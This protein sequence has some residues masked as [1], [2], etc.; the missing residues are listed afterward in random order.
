MFKKYIKSL[1]AT[2]FLLYVICISIIIIYG[3]YRCDHVKD[4]LDVLEFE[5]FK[6]SSKYGIDG[7]SLTHLSFNMMIGYLYPKTLL[8]SMVLGGI[9]EL[10]ETYAGIYKPEL[11]KGFGFCDTDKKTKVWWYGKKSDIICNFIGFMLGKTIREKL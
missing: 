9:W 5:A 8:P 10:F 4:H 2:Y 7:W 1:D 3:K 11:L 6:G